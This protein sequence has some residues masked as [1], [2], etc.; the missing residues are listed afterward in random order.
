MTSAAGGTAATSSASPAAKPL[1]IG[2]VAERAG[3]NIQTL[4]Y[5]ERVSLLPKPRRS[6][7]GY[8]LYTEETIRIVSFV[9]R[10]QELGFTLREVKEL[11]RLRTAGLTRRAAVRA[12]AEAKVV[13]IDARI[14]DLTAIRGALASLLASCACGHADKP[15][16]PILEALEK[17]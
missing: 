5:Y 17:K 12:A 8:R 16:C 6:G 11:L 7:A 4:R 13:D 15:D 14:E 1:T 3:V 9:K 10:A 2:K